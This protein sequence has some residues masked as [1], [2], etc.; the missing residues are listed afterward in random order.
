MNVHLTVSLVGLA[1]GMVPL[2]R[3]WL[4][5]RNR[6]DVVEDARLMGFH[7]MM[8]RAAEEQAADPRTEDTK[9]RFAMKVGWSEPYRGTHRL[10][11]RIFAN[12]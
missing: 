9:R 2:W 7:T 11:D 10:E 8:R 12:A 6:R 5:R 4:L 3:A 1:L